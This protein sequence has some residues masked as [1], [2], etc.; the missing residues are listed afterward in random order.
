M[1]FKSV[2]TSFVALA[3]FSIFSFSVYAEKRDQTYVKTGNR[4]ISKST[5]TLTESP[6]HEVTQEVL[7]Q[8]S[9]YSS[10]D[11]QV[12]E[13]WIYIH[14]DQI[15][16]TGTHKGYY[17]YVLIGGEQA[18]GTFEGSHKTVA[19]EDGSWTSTWDGTYKY[20]G[21]TGK[22]KNIKGSGTYKGKVGSKEPFYEEG[23]DKIEY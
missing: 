11:F 22:Y 23:R 3:V 19:K 17:T 13:E 2:F 21:G 4:S 20:L 8:N 12:T 18:Y 9:K 1:R 10:P 5:I 15:D 6:N 14:S 7:L 16:G